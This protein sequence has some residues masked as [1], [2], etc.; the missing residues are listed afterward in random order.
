V[1]LP[2]AQPVVIDF[3]TAAAASGKI[4][5]MRQT[6]EALPEGWILDV[7]GHPSTNPED[8]YNGGMLLPAAGHKGYALCLLVELLAG[9]LT[10]A[11]SP[12]LPDSGY[13]VGNGLFLQAFDVEAFM[14]LETF[15]GAARTLADEV[16]AMP[17][18]SGHDRVML[19]G[20]PERGLA[21]Q[22]AKDGI[23]VPDS[24]WESV[25]REATDLGITTAGK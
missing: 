20:E 25:V 4:R 15:A 24:V 14:P 17:P 10:G 1:P 7:E 12:G 18:A 9:C 23:D 3:S 6:G 11:G 5:V 8:Y 21:A 19:P 13:R 2:G 16:H 22:R